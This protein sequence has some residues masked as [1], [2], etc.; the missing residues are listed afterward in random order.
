MI[1]P[2]FKVSPAAEQVRTELIALLPTTILFFSAGIV[3]VVLDA[4]GWHHSISLSCPPAPFPFL[5]FRSNQTE[6]GVLG[7]LG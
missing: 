3:I 5:S 7:E 4:V 1:R 6:R 2:M